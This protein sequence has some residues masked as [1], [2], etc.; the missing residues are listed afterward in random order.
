[1]PNASGQPASCPIV[2]GH[3]ECPHVPIGSV[4]AIVRLTRLTGRQVVEEGAPGGAPYPERENLV[5]EEHQSGIVI[6]VTG[7]NLAQDFSL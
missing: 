4:T 3:Y 5:P 7:D 2:E 6:N 1:M